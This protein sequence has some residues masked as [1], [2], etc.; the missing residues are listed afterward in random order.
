RPPPR[1]AGAIFQ[2]D[3]GLSPKTGAPARL[4]ERRSSPM[5]RFGDRARLA[6]LLASVA[7]SPFA[8]CAPAYAQDDAGYNE[9]EGIVV[10]ARRRE[11][12]LQDVPV[13]VTA[14]SAD[15]LDATGARDITAIGETT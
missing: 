1:S 12:A 3:R 9:E 4:E 2:R 6:L 14:Y 5:K 7:A 15:E 8:L 11:E 13:A 10:T